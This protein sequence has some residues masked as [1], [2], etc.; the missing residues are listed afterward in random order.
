MMIN[1]LEDNLGI[2]GLNRMSCDTHVKRDSSE[3]RLSIPKTSNKNNV[4]K[5]DKMNTNKQTEKL[6]K[7]KKMM[8]IAFADA[9]CYLEYRLGNN[10]R[11]SNYNQFMDLA[12]IGNRTSAWFDFLDNN[13]DKEKLDREHHS[14]N[15]NSSEVLRKLKNNS[16]YALIEEDGIVCEVWDQNNLDDVDDSEYDEFYLHIREEAMALRTRML[17]KIE[18]YQKRKALEIVSE[19][20][21]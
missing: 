14:W 8:S 16:Y 17:I 4:L 10:E 18:E 21:K 2:K 12:L 3:R 1:Y 7:A 11:L 9:E 19:E 5:E 13:I 20:G 15:Q 6:L